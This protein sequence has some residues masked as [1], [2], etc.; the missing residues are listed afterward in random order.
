M[1]LR[2]KPISQTKRRLHP[3]QYILHLAYVKI[4]DEPFVAAAFYIDLARLSVLQQH[5]R[6]SDRD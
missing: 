3:R 5:K 4:A 6:E 2:S 1:A